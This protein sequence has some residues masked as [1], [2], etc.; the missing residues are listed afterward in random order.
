[1]SVRLARQTP[2]IGSGPLRAPPRRPRFGRRD[3]PQFSPP[4]RRQFSPPHRRPSRRH[5][6]RALF[7]RSCRPRRYLSRPLR[8]RSRVRHATR[9]S[10]LGSSVRFRS[11]LAPSLF[12]PRQGRL[13]WHPR[14]RPPGHRN[15]GG[16]SRFA[17]RAL[18]PPGSQSC[19]RPIHPSSHERRRSGTSST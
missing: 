11:S 18:R 10:R 5:R 7:R 4:H 2:S 9:L 15:R 3:P 16:P 8:R 13:P 1:M 14:A 19:M 17:R 12:D 6:F